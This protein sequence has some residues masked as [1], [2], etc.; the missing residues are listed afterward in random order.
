V[1]T[2]KELTQMAEYLKELGMVIVS[3]DFKNGTITV[4]PIPHLSQSRWSTQRITSAYARQG[5]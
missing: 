3:I 1:T 2:K 4:K 5:G